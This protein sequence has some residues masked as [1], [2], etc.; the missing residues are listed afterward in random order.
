MMELIC[1][2]EERKRLETLAENPLEDARVACRAKIILEC[3]DGIPAEE[4]ASNFG[5]SRSMIF[6]W[7]SRYTKEGIAGLR[8][9]PRTGKPPIYDEEFE[10]R[11][12]EM[13]EQ[14]P[15]S[16]QN[17]WDGAALA[18]ALQASDDAVWR[19]LRRHGIALS[20]Q[21]QWHVPAGK[22]LQENN[23]EV[24]GIYIAPP[25]AILVLREGQ[26]EQRP[27]HIFTHD[28][29]AGSALAE[30]CGPG[31]NL[32]LCD[33]IEILSRYKRDG[34]NDIRPQE[35]MIGLLNDMLANRAPE[36]RVYVLVLG[37]AAELGMM[38]WMAAHADV[39]VSFFAS[40]EEGAA[41]LEEWIPMKDGKG[42]YSPLTTALLHYPQDAHSFIWKKI[43]DE[44][45]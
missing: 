11:V 33:A 19:V 31:E 10:K 35:E 18:Q 24:E 27:A 34:Q 28:K 45:G 23:P 40:M 13:L 30:A 8:D 6:R 32:L 15:P 21:R 7:R 12:F 39:A 22:R 5:V 14:A 41:A 16:G 4:I 20:R 26:Q 17:R 1:S 2:D 38:G 44:K 36:E 37:S 9:K 42:Q 25:A 3:L 29:K 43:R